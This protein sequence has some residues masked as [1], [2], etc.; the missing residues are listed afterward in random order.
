MKPAFIHFAKS[1]PAPSLWNA[2]FREALAPLGTLRIVAGADAWT[3]EDKTKLA[4]EHDVIISG[5]G[6]SSIPPELARNPGKLR[7]ICHLTGTL[8]GQIGPELVDSPIAVTNWGD[9]PAFGIAEGALALLLASLK[10][11]HPHIEDKRAGTWTRQ[12]GRF[13]NGSL[14]G[15]RI[16]FYGVGA[17]GRRFAE[18]LRPFGALLHGY[19]PNVAELPSGMRRVESLRELFLQADVV[20]LHA[21]AT[22]ETRRTVTGDLLKLLPDGGILINTARGALV[23][24]DA[25]F[26]ELGTGRLRAG[27]D[28]LDQPEYG[29]AL[30]P[31]HPARQYPNL[32][33]T[34]HTV[35]GNHWPPGLEE[36]LQPLHEVAL[37][38][39]GRFVRGE[40]LLHRITP[41]RYGLMT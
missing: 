17:I 21:G 34:A 9:V 5:W 25:L 33:L 41:V 36:T 22:D 8:R 20:S 30:S 15:L 4:R 39:L 23:D 32:I 40:D 19:D 28:V 14:R 7:Y 1:E 27:L 35:G 13:G 16:G 12:P 38:N 24:E 31:T 6:G 18:M 37:D 10:N 2:R 3:D 29:D 26:A 11:L